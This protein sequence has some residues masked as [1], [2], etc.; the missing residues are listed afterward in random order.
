MF[1]NSQE[2]GELRAEQERLRQRRAERESPAIK[3][4]GA[5]LKQRDELDKAIEK[6]KQTQAELQKEVR[7]PKY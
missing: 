3:A 2:I 4:V 6:E 7:V 1:V 5:L